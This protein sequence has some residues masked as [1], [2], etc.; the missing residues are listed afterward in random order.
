LI[1]LIDSIVTRNNMSDNKTSNNNNKTNAKS[2]N[3]TGNGGYDA[4]RQGSMPPYPPH[5]MMSMPPRAPY[6]PP[7]MTTG[8]GGYPPHMMAMHHAAFAPMPFSSQQKKNS[9]KT[10]RS[11]T[12]GNQKRRYS[13][14][15]SNGQ[16]ETSVRQKGNGRQVDQGRGKQN[17]G[18]LLLYL[19]EYSNVHYS[20]TFILFSLLLH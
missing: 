20:L 7:H 4:S 12:N 19:H 3:N 10:P 17:D 15:T 9:Y 1:L 14:I 11:N 6:P 18:V 13:S 2:N 8:R 5:H 16:S